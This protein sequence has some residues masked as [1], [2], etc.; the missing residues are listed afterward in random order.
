MARANEARTSVTLKNDI[1]PASRTGA[2]VVVQ[3][4]NKRASSLENRGTSSWSRCS[5]AQPH[6]GGSDFKIGH[7]R[8]RNRNSF[9]RSVT[10]RSVL[11]RRVR[12][13]NARSQPTPRAAIP[14]AARCRRSKYPA[15]RRVHSRPCSGQLAC[16]AA[17]ARDTN[18]CAAVATARA[19]AMAPAL[20]N[21][22][23]PKWHDRFGG[24]IA[25]MFEG[26][27]GLIALELQSIER[28]TALPAQ[29]RA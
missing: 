25:A 14:R 7:F 2:R 29:V 12:D 3:R 23:R 10:V 1:M 17:L 24:G 28:D 18:C 15:R 26:S 16:C 9:T 6:I 21:S 27:V 5:I 20:A 13:E 8:K 4:P 11:L 19:V 22:A